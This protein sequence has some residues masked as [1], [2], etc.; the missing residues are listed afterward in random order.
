MR[1]FVRTLTVSICLL[2]APAL[3]KDVRRESVQ[4]RSGESAW[5]IGCRLAILYMELGI[6]AEDIQRELDEALSSEPCRK[7]MAE[8]TLAGRLRTIR[9][10]IRELQTEDDAAYDAAVVGWAQPGA[11]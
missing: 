6:S 10:R 8:I 4:P 1:G 5:L 7:A 3:A 9:D 11:R 2:V